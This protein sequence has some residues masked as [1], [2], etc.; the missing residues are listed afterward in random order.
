MATSSSEIGEGF[1]GALIGAPMA[2]VIVQP[3]LGTTLTYVRV[4]GLVFAASGWS[5]WLF[6][7]R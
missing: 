5:R 2:L 7:W 1:G 4:C 6:C 3:D